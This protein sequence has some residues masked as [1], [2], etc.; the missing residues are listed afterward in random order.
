MIRNLVLLLSMSL[1]IVA[2]PH[3]I[4][5]NFTDSTDKAGVPGTGVGNGIAFADYDSDGDLDLY[6]SSDPRDILYRNNNGTFEDVTDAAGISIAGDGVAAAFGD[7]DNDGDLDLYIS[8]NDGQDIFFQNEGNGTF[9]D[10]SVLV[11]ISNPDRAR[12]ASFADFDKDGF[13]DIYVANENA[14]NILYRN[15]NGSK[16]ENVAEEMNVGHQ[17][18]GRCSV[19]FD[20]DN[21][22]DLDLYVTNK[23]STN[24]LY[25]NEG[26]RFRNVTEFAGVEGM[27]NSTGVDV[28]DY[29]NDGYLDICVDGDQTYLYHNNGDGTFTDVAAE[30]GVSHSGRE[31]TPAFGDYD[32]DGNIDL[33]LAVWGGEAV[34]YRNNG[35]GTFEDVTEEANLGA[36]GS[37]WSAVFADYDS[38]G[39]LDLYASYT[40]RENIL[41]QNNGNDNNWLQIKM[42]GGV[43]NRDGIGTR[44]EI[45]VGGEFQIREV[46]ASSGYGSQD[47]LDVEFGL[48]ENTAAEVVEIKWP[49]GI[50]TR[51][52]DIQANRMMVAEENFLAV[53]TTE[54]QKSSS[55][56]TASS[57]PCLLPNYPNPFNPET[58]IPFRLADQAD[59]S[60]K[61]YDVSGHLVRTL[62]V[63]HR[64]PGEYKS[65]G[66]S[67]HWDGRSDG[68]E[69]VAAGIYFY[70]I[71]AG[72][73]TQ[74]RKMV[75]R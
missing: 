21:D 25:R 57:K 30:S 17:G 6:V 3:A 61:I 62:R 47:S 2:T 70:Q 52:T 71:I 56:S 29:D 51:W 43:S 11:G 66:E 41:Y 28:A 32:N 18:S 68:G 72:N 46:T 59:V 40:T 27:G 5:T 34:M 65:K 22:Y 8:V 50:V 60:I 69:I 26:S 31:S 75:L 14:A 35:N 45:T 54:Y 33:Y 38:D 12:S 9:V 36:S 53:E 13:L 15:I 44:I 42:L 74:T 24:V 20:Y 37:S 7:Y 63:G 73:F 67:A 23:G 64:R 16:F 58:W 19:W 1:W 39:D 10:M 4:I 55:E 49:S 48:G